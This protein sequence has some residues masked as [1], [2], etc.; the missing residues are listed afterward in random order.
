MILP[1]IYLLF[2]S[3]IYKTP[4]IKKFLIYLFY[5][6][7]FLAPYLFYQFSLFGLKFWHFPNTW[8]FSEGLNSYIAQNFWGYPQKRTFEYYSGQWGFLVGGLPLILLSFLSVF[9][10]ARENW[11]AL[12]ICLLFTL[13]AIL[14]YVVGVIPFYQQYNYLLSLSLLVFIPLFFCLTYQV[15]VS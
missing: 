5:I 12:V 2:F 11:R 8:Y 4:P 1:L 14:P 3:F 6:L 9:S 13:L 10:L 15:R 7:I